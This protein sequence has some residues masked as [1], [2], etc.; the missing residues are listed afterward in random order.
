VYARDLR[1]RIPRRTLWAYPD[2]TVICGKPHVESIPGVGDSATNP[3]VIVEVL[4]PST[5]PYDRG[6]KFARYREIETLREYVLI[7]QREPR[8]EVFRRT[9][10]GGWASDPFAGISNTMTLR[11]LNVSVGLGGAL[12]GRG[13]R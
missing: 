5:E 13:I 2:A 10:D 6:D 3:H 4:S 9:D 8:V 7:S 11:S 1:I 12:R